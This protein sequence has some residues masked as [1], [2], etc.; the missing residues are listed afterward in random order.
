MA[1]VV[2]VEVGG[3]AAGERELDEVRNVESQGVK[4][5]SL[6]LKGGEERLSGVESL[7]RWDPEK[8][9]ANWGA[10]ARRGKSEVPRTSGMRGG[11]GDRRLAVTSRVEMEDG[12]KPE[13]W[14]R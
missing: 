4:R 7:R 2:E 11:Y 10:G 9:G 14:G 13:E 3:A 12:E 8:E 6:N 5:L 1:A